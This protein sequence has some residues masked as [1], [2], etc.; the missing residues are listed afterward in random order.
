[1]G[2]LHSLAENW[3]TLLNAVGIIG[4]LTY[5][6]YYLCN[7]LIQLV[8]LRDGGDILEIAHRMVGWQRLLVPSVG[9]LAAGLVL[10]VGLR[11]MTFEGRHT[12]PAAGPF[13]QPLHD[14]MVAHD[15]LTA[16]SRQPALHLL[17][18]CDRLGLTPNL[19]Q[20]QTLFARIC[21]RNLR[22]LLRRRL[23][24][25]VIARQVSLLHRLGERLGFYA[26]E[27]LPLEEW[28]Q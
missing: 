27:G 12:R 16:A 4:G 17:E 9:G 10:L 2:S 1:M 19:W 3:F 23:H 25:E 18:F 11:R 21:Q 20:A 7:Q 5:W 6:V 15:S 13:S 24:D 22:S 8:L 14:L 28:E 26:V